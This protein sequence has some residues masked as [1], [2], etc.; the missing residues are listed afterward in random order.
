MTSLLMETPLTAEQQEYVETIR[1][2]GKACSASSTIFWI[3]QI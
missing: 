2:S 1:S 3:F